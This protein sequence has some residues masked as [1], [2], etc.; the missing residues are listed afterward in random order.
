MPPDLYSPS[1]LAIFLV[2]LLAFFL[3]IRE[4][5]CW[6]FKLNKIVRLLESIDASLRTLP[7]VAKSRG[8]G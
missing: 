5:W 4:F 6:Y 1:H 7:S 3:L 2:I 8:E